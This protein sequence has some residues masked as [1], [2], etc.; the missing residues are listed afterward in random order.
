MLADPGDEGG[1][2]PLSKGGALSLGGSPAQISAPLGVRECTTVTV[3]SRFW[4]SM[5]AG[6]P[7]MLERPTTTARLPDMGILYLVSISMQPWGSKG[8]EYAVIP[9]AG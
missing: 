1:A 9:D 5:D 7:T 6:R 3:A 8:Q 2:V 4:R